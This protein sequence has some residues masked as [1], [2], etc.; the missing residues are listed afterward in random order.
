MTNQQKKKPTKKSRKSYTV[1]DIQRAGYNLEPMRCIF[2]GSHEVTY[3]QYIGDALCGNCGRWQNEDKRIKS[4]H[5]RPGVGRHPGHRSREVLPSTI[6]SP[7][8]HAKIM[9][10]ARKKFRQRTNM[11]AFYEHGHWWLRRGTEKFDYWYDV[12]DAEGYGSI[13][14]FD[15]ELIDEMEVF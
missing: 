8:I 12:V 14:G 15:F 7:S 6:N 5:T 13:D 10:A 11:T 9:T 4:G 2:C 3:N 1:N